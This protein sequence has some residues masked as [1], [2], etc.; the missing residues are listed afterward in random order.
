MVHGEQA[1]GSIAA[2]Q[3]Y[4]RRIG[5]PD[6]LVAVPDYQIMGVTDINRLEGRQIPGASRQFA[7]RQKFG[8]DATTRR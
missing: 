1:V 8:G 2:R 5:K 3:N 4:Q 6:V 7:Q